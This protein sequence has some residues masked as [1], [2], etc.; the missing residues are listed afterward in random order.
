MPDNEAISYQV[1]RSRRKTIAIQITAQGA[2][3]VRCPLRMSEAAIERFVQSKARWIQK[4]LEKKQ[5]P[6]PALTQEEVEALARHARQVIPARAAH[7]APLVG[8]TYGR[9][10]IRSQHSRWGSCSG[11]GNLNFNCLLMLVPADVMDY[12]VVHE[13][14]HRR[15][16]NHSAR[17]W[18]EVER[19]LPDYRAARTWLKENGQ[20]LIGRLPDR[21]Q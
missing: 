12:V 8:V 5:P 20:S 4:H 19:I 3:I 10:T 18:A 13:L 15:E 17:F 14:C 16:M 2:V 11:K 7:F 6:Q 21:R 9:I 1:V